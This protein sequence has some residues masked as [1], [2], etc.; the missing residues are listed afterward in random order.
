MSEYV[1]EQGIL[2]SGRSWMYVCTSFVIW[3]NNKL[4]CSQKMGQ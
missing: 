2:P 3:I 1:S 4:D